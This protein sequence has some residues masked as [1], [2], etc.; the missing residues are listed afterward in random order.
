MSHDIPTIYK[1]FKLLWQVMNNDVT[2]RILLNISVDFLKLLLSK[3]NVT[4]KGKESKTTQLQTYLNRVFLNI[5]VREMFDIR[6][7]PTKKSSMFCFSSIFFSFWVFFHKHLQTF[8]HEGE[9]ISLTHHYPFHPPHRHL[10][11]SRAIT[12][13][14]SPLHIDSS[15]TWTGNLWFPSTS[16]ALSKRHF[17][18][19]C[20]GNFGFY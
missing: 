10:D 13:E 8:I 15:R 5:N 11:F 2:D 20:K 3:K 17:L 14:S 7:N 12:A 1:Y 6:Q 4:W 9:G 16:L 18:V 19:I